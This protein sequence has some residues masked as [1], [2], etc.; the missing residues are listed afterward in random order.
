M[1]IPRGKAT[2]IER[3]IKSQFAWTTNQTVF[4][5]SIF[6][7]QHIPFSCYGAFL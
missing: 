1:D 2:G 4:L 6:I 3:F 5:R 7:L